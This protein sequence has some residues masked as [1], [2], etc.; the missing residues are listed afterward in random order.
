MD[1]PE[2]FRYYSN[3]VLGEA[4]EIDGPHSSVATKC[5]VV[6]EAEKKQWRHFHQ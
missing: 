5:F 6:W 4:A 2:I 3:H 1:V